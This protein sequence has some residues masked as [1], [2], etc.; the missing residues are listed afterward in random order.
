MRL[1]VT[2]TRTPQAYAIIRA[3]RPHAS[4]VV[5]TIE[6][7]G[8]AARLSHAAH[9]R[10]VDE[11]YRVPLPIDDWSAGRISET[12]TP[13]EQA[14]IDAVARVCE[15]ER[16]TV[17]YPSW[18]PYVYIFSKNL[19][20]FTARGVTIPVPA[21]E[22]VLTALDKHRTLQAARAAGFPCPGSCLYESLEQLD[23]LA[24]R[25]GYP[26]VLK[27][28][29][30]SGGHGMAIVRDRSE[31][32]A[33]LPAI[34]EKHGPPLVQEYIP[35]GDR[36]SV[37]F[38]IARDGALLFAFHKHRTRTFRR[39]ARFGTVS[40]SASPA[41]RLAHTAQFVRQL[42]W[43]GAMG[44]E[45]MRD[46][47]DGVAKLMEVNPRFPRQLWNRTEL[48]I[49]EPLMCVQLARGEHVPPIDGCPEGILFVSPVEDLQL[50][51]LQLTD[52]VVYACR[53]V[54]SGARTFDSSTAP[55]GA[56]AQTRSFA[57]TYVSSKRKVWDPYFRYFF[58]DPK[59]SALWWLQF[60]TWLVGSRKQ[61]GK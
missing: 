47:R 27:P 39:T 19:A 7:D 21:F 43:W 42:G 11:R 46:P 57:Q 23:Q 14:F 31:A 52:S 20:F 32:E 51:V 17:L 9:S 1:L 56:G 40:E 37:Q 38:V 34:L 33:S 5:A 30:T 6:G 61:V 48:G 8:L 26:L 59:A 49:N 12:N 24:E 3:L 13:A 35:G 22:T 58:Q 50:F 53:R 18:D 16:I 2:N 54:F 41:A 45:T 10:L 36:D 29:F 25:W 44:I 60:S 4:R 28:R 15:R 55:P